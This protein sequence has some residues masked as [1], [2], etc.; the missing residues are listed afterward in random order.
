MRKG[1]GR[2]LLLGGLAGAAAMVCQRRR[3]ERSRVVRNRS[4]AVMVVGDGAQARVL[5]VHCAR[6]GINV[7]LLTPGRALPSGQWASLSYSELLTGLRRTA[8]VPV[9]SKADAEQAYDLVIVCASA[10]QLSS[11]L[12]ATRGLRETCRVI[13]MMDTPGSLSVAEAAFSESSALAGSLGWLA[14]ETDHAVYALPVS[15]VRPVLGDSQGRE[16]ARLREAALILRQAGL[17]VETTDCITA[18]LWSHAGMLAA[19]VGSAHRHGSLR[20]F[21]LSPSGLSGYLAQLRDLCLVLEANGIPVSRALRRR[22]ALGPESL[23]VWLLRLFLVTPCADL[24]L[25]RYTA[26]LELELKA[27][28]G[29]LR[30]L[31]AQVEL[32]VPALE[33]LSLSLPPVC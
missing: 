22:A 32:P 16:T 8:R 18:W 5:A 12:D 13:T 17:A 20:R 27:V 4:V 14:Y 24:L 29:Q 30:G 6:V 15:M 19:L 28:V 26:V 3:A 31:A 7:T 33:S 2:A 25:T 10:P 11:A 21:A 23:S 9:I 1:A